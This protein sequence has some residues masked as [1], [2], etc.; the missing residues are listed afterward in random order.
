MS[1]NRPGRRDPGGN[2]A[3][4]PLAEPG[5]PVR[6]VVIDDEPRYRIDLGASPDLIQDLLLEPVGGYCDV[7]TFLAIHRQP[8][9]VVVLDLCLNRCTGDA[10]VLQ[11]VRAIRHLSADLGHRVLV[12]SAD[13]RPEPVARCVANGSAARMSA[14]R[15]RIARREPTFAAESTS[16]SGRTAAA[17]F[18]MQRAASGMSC[19]T[20]TSPGPIRSAM[21]WLVYPAEARA[22]RRRSVSDA[23]S[24]PLRRECTRPSCLSQVTAV[25]AVPCDLRVAAVRR[26]R[27]PLAG[28][29]PACGARLGWSG[30]LRLRRADDAR[31]FSR[32][33]TEQ[34]TRPGIAHPRSN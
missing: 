20:Q 6:Y 32:S 9:H 26:P 10:A 2:Q 27:R 25:A 12:F 31:S 4:L 13:A 21:P 17:P 33:V 30:R 8:C 14:M 34:G 1:G 11:G 23:A 16:P 3:V 7:E 18:S 29:G 22:S 28:F 19:V 5:R 24:R 15:S